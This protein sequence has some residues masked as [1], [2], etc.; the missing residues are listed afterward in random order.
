M[1][2]YAN[3]DVSK[4]DHALHFSSIDEAVAD[5]SAGLGLRTKEQEA[6]LRDFLDRKLRFEDGSYVL[7]GITYE[8]K[9]WWEKEG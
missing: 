3:V 2:I 1:G 8:A 9:I 7:D 6:V 5:Q 4:E